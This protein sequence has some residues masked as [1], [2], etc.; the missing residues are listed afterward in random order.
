MKQLDKI[1]AVRRALEAADP[2]PSFLEPA[3]D[4]KT[5]HS[6]GQYVCPFCGHGAHGDGLQAIKGSPAKW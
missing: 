2:E 1:K 5:V 6:H 4:H 3:A